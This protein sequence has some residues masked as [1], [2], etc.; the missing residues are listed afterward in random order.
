[1]NQ[2][3]SSAYGRAAPAC[4]KLGHKKS[5]RR[6]GPRRGSS[7]QLVTRASR[8]DV[9]MDADAKAVVVLILDG[10]DR[11]RLGRAGQSGKSRGR[12]VRCRLQLLVDHIEAH[13]EPR[14]EVVL[15]PGTDR[16]PG[17]VVVALPGGDL[18]CG[19][20]ERARE[21]GG[22]ACDGEGVGH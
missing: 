7:A 14:C 8:N 22:R 3:T 9:A 17:E 11:S 5:P 21:G 20:I 13:I 6:V 18:S 4:V 19:E 1:M 10:I 2:T 16:P 15:G 12:P